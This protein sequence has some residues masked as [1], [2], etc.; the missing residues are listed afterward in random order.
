[1]RA[2]YDSEAN[3]ISIDLVDVERWE[4]CEAAGDRVNV[5]FS[6][7]RRAVNVELLYPTMGID[8]PLQAAARLHGLDAETLIAAARAAEAAPN[9]SVDL[10][11][12]VRPVA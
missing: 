9:R 11:I 1:M 7:D 5:A 2:N 10:D 12:G 6:I 8:A 4:Y 3:A